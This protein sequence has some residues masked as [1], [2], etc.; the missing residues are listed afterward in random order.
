MLHEIDEIDRKIISIEDS[1]DLSDKICFDKEDSEKILKLE[2]KRSA[3]FS[4][5]RSLVTQFLTQ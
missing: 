1:L 2:N 4:E 5:M 3:I